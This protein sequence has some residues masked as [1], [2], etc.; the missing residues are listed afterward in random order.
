[1]KNVFSIV[2]LLFF[3]QTAISAQQKDAL[4][5]SEY[6]SVP[7]LK[8][9]LDTLASAAMEGRETGTNGAQRAASYISEQFCK[10]GLSVN[11][12]YQQRFEI[13]K[14]TLVPLKINVGNKEFL[15]GID[16]LITTGSRKENE[17]NTHEIV[18]AG[19]GIST[20]IYDDYADLDVKNK[21]VVI[22]P[23]EPRKEGNY[24]IS[25]NENLSY[26]GK[27][28]SAKILNAG[29]RGAVALLVINPSEDVFL[30]SKDAQPGE[31][32][33]Q[34]ST[35][36]VVN[37]TR[38]MFSGIFNEKLVKEILRKKDSTEVFPNVDVS[39]KAN[40]SLKYGYI[41]LPS[42][43]ANVIG[44]I[45]GSMYPDEYVFITGHYDHKG[46]IDGQIYYGA[47]DNASG[48]SG[49]LAIAEAFNEAAK[50]G[51]PP[52]RSI[53]FIAFDGEELGLLGSDF[54]TKNPF[55][56][57]EKISAVLN[58][59]M[60]GRVQQGKGGRRNRNYLYV[61][62]NDRLSSDLDK[63]LKLVKG[64]TPVEEDY[65]Y[66]N[67]NDPERLFERSDHYNFAQKGVPVLFFT[68]GLHADYHTP[69]DTA[70]KIEFDVLENR[71]KYIFLVAW[72]IANRKEMMRRNKK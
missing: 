32:I 56:P 34:W 35:I 40:I 48:I 44:M 46:I 28:L 50:N 18:F 65:K 53:V 58:I 72:E 33:N 31:N 12:E 9:H 36:P 64:K 43:A 29:K 67:P 30:T 10:A 17:F 54:Y 45:K 21:V 60:I 41:K 62:G 42:S 63:V 22:F 66:N 2:I 69:G 61:I 47:D 3:F 5:Y 49:I 7:Q 59:D 25:G 20:S 8:E 4:Y 19:Y 55:F 71:T 38:A 52:E 39:E 15:L 27:D 51:A 68:G 70:D 11:P 57:L 1:M 26:W 16:Y 13:S 6:I 14:D 23:G 24:L 37:I